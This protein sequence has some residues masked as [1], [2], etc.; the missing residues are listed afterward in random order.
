[1]FKFDKDLEEVVENTVQYDNS[2][3]SYTICQLQLLRDAVRK[4]R[5]EN[6]HDRCWLDDQELYKSLPEVKDADYQLP[7]RQEFLHNCSK[8]W[9]ERQPDTDLNSV[10]AGDY[11]VKDKA[12][13]LAIAIRE[14]KISALDSNGNHFLFPLVLVKNDGWDEK[15]YY[16]KSQPL[17]EL[18]IPNKNGN[19]WTE[20]T[21][22]GYSSNISAW[23]L[24]RRAE[25]EKREQEH[26]KNCRYMIGYQYET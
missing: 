18:N 17:V 25:R 9:C 11:F 22:M 14:D 23:K 15:T 10:K 5:D 2:Y 24:K 19:I 12:Q 8:Y 16:I 21:F 26:L 3:I 6:G 1:M 13:Y 4:H 7:P 20:K